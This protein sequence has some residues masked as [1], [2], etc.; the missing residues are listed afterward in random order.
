[1]HEWPDLYEYEADLLKFFDVTLK[2]IENDWH[3]TPRVRVTVLDPGHDDTVNRPEGGWPL[4]DL[5]PTRFYLDAGNGALSQEA[6]KNS[7][8]ITYDASTGVATCTYEV[9]QK[10]EIGGPS[11]LRLWVEAEGADDLDIY[12]FIQKLGADG[13]PLLSQSLPGVWI[14]VAT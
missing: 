10:L 1:T 12:A 5:R 8:A 11:K 4:P 9:Q 14:P 7:T 3:Q 2:Q 6:R 13:T